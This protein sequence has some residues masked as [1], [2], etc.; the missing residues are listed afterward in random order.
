MKKVAY[1]F[2]LVGINH[3]ARPASGS[4]PL[5]GFKLESGFCASSHGLWTVVV[6]LDVSC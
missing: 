3:G 6:A 4:R 5:V 2:F 1:G